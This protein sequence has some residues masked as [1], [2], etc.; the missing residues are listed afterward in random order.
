MRPV[1]ANQTGLRAG[2]DVE[3]ELPSRECRARQGTLLIAH[4]RETPE[5]VA[6]DLHVP[7]EFLKL[8]GFAAIGANPVPVSRSTRDASRSRSR[9]YNPEAAA[10]EASVHGFSPLRLD[11]T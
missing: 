8:D 2:R 9:S 1:V 7:D 3:R 5:S 6:V 4:G 10:L 11:A